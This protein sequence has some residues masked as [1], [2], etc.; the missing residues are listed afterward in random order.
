MSYFIALMLLVGGI[1]IAFFIHQNKKKQAALTA[2]QRAFVRSKLLSILRGSLP[3]F[4][5]EFDAFLI[6]DT[7]ESLYFNQAK[8][9]DWQSKT[10]DIYHQIKPLN[11]AL[12]DLKIVE[13]ALIQQFLA[14]FEGGDGIRDSYNQKFIAHSLA[15][16]SDFFDDIE[17]RKLDSQ[18][19]IAVVTDEDS[20]L[21]IAG[22]GSGKTTTIAGKVAYLIHRYQLK[23]EDILLISFT[24]K[25]AQEM[26]KRIAQKMGIKINVFTFHKLGKEIIAES[27]GQHPS[28]FDENTKRDVIEN[29][30]LELVQDD[31]FKGKIIDFFVD[32]LKIPPDDNFRNRGQYIQYLKDQNIRTLKKKQ[33][34][35]KEGR[36]TF[37]RETCKSFEEVKIANFLLL[38]GIKY[39]YETPY[40]HATADKKFAQYKPDFFLPDYN[41]YIEHW[42][43]D[44]Q[45]NVPQWFTNENGYHDAN[46]KYKM[47]MVWK[48]DLHTKHGTI[49]VETSSADHKKGVLLTQLKADLEAEGVVFT[50]L[51]EEQILALIKNDAPEDY[52]EFINLTT[53]FLAL[54]KSNNYTIDDVQEKIK[55]EKNGRTEARNTH[56]SYIFEEIL[57]QYNAHLKKRNEID[58]S[59]MINQATD[60]LNKNAINRHYKYVLI[61]EFQDISL[62]RFRLVK[63]LLEQNEGT[64]IFAVGD[65]WQSIYRFAGSDI[66]MFTEFSN[67]FGTTAVNHIETTYRFNAHLID[68]SSHFILKNPNQVKKSLKSYHAETEKSYEILYSEADKMETDV[69]INALKKV[70]EQRK[71]DAIS[72]KKDELDVLILGRYNADIDI[73]EKDKTNFKIERTQ[74][75]ICR[76]ISTDF[77]ELTMQFMTVH[78]AKGL[79]ADY[80][81]VWNC[82]AGKNGFPSERTDDSL[83]NL[84]LTQADQFPNGEERRLFYVALTRCRKRVYLTTNIASPSKFI[85][86]LEEAEGNL[87]TDK[88]PACKMGNLTRKSGITKQ[89]KP[90]IRVTCLNANYGCAYVGWDKI[91]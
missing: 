28:I 18:Q 68:L 71:T 48:R 82:S 51:N 19:R 37:M 5:K 73:I 43:I 7:P 33:A 74:D 61:D 72:T 15:I 54:F 90:Y 23:S 32:H 87:P 38:N 44:A 70:V 76:V 26:Q 56:F 88:C 58:F 67:Y 83:L 27:K 1:F 41:I 8:L 29:I 39:S 91:D 17:G 12:A 62:G 81:I 20:N 57:R 14:Y 30:V 40:P 2:E 55:A 25:A 80:A 77:P 4:V 35:F 64:K 85:D 53:T 47:G 42:G 9:T 11:L 22:A 63:A 50:P 65:D 46:A 36:R 89:G 69:L 34:Q 3:V 31:R 45:G 86:E 75:G 84:L 78:K 21:I 24:R 13:N 60:L 66:A 59:D 79:E 16:Y 49:L 52:E 10:A 6:H